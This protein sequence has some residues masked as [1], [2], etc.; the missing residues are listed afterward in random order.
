MAGETD[1]PT[2]LRAMDPC[3]HGEPFIFCSVDQATFD[4]LRV[5]PTGLFREAE[6]ITLILTRAQADAA[7]LPYDAL[8]ACITLSVHSALSA[9]GFIAA[10]SARF[11]AAGLSTNPV[12]G[13]YHDHLFVPWHERE[14]ALREL[15]A[16]A[17]GAAD[18]A[19]PPA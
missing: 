9:V 4:G 14:R 18:E 11:A 6:G 3:L 8:W 17:Q 5:A 10:I 19:Q 1:L 2:L 15:A 12:A 13:Y 7:G 16:L